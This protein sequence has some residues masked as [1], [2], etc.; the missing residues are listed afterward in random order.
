MKLWQELSLP[1]AAVCMQEVAYVAPATASK[2]QHDIR[3]PQAPA[4]EPPS[5]PD[6]VLEPPAAAQA[7]EQLLERQLKTGP[8]QLAQVWVTHPCTW[9]L[10]IVSTQLT[11]VIE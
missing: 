5:P 8:S 11:H 7:E 2:G 1:P 9:D 4:D 6:D 3:R 10:H